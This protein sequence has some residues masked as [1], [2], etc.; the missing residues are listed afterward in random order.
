MADLGFTDVIEM[1]LDLQPVQNPARV[2]SYA[3]WNHDIAREWQGA[4][5]D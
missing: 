3:T 4:M 2:H 5:V 1:K